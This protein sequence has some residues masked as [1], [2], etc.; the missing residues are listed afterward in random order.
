MTTDDPTRS[1]MIT[2]RATFQGWTIWEKGSGKNIRTRV[3]FPLPYVDK[4]DFDFWRSQNPKGQQAGSSDTQ[5]QRP[6]IG[7]GGGAAQHRVPTATEPWR[8]PSQKPNPTI[9]SM[10]I[11]PQITT[12]AYSNS[13]ISWNNSALTSSKGCCPSVLH[14]WT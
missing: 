12:C 10:H 4:R 14:P 5:W 6:H 13:S 2:A 8:N 1:V 7:T 3:P 11:D 9:S